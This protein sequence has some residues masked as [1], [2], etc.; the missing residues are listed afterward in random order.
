MGPGSE[1][2]VEWLQRMS[3]S[4]AFFGTVELLLFFSVV[5]NLRE[6]FFLVFPVNR[7]LQADDNHQ[8]YAWWAI[9]APLNETV[10]EINFELLCEF[11]SNEHKLYALDKADVND[12][13]EGVHHI[14]AEVL[15]A[16]ESGS[17][18]PRELIVKLGCLLILLQN[19]NVRRGLCNDTRLT[20]TGI[21]RRALQ[22]RLPNGSY[23]LLPQ[24]NFT[25]EEQGLPWVLQ[26]RQFPVKLAFALSINKSQGQSLD[27]VGVDIR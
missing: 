6:L 14:P 3:S 18:L 26:R 4:P 10:K 27:E 20:L 13:E 12:Q 19:L 9:L 23:E 7:L 11:R 5:H 21:W 17:V 2:Y 1:P 25:V 16:Q 24:I 8:W 22:V 15:R